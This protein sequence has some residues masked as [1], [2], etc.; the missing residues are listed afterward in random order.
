MIAAPNRS[1]SALRARAVL[2]KDTIE[3]AERLGLSQKVLSKIIGQP[4]S[5]VSRMKSGDDMLDGG[6]A[7]ELAALFVRLYRSLDAIVAG[8]E[9]AAREW[10]K[11][12]N[13]A[14]GGAPVDLI[15]KVQGL[16]HVVQYLDAR[17]A[18]V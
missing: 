7:F 15:Q 3:A 14:L 16:F 12:E 1:P 4:D 8:D 9:T 13:L 2:T 10:I 17:R 11:A 18:P 5:V 6:K